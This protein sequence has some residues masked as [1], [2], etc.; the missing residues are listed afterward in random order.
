MVRMK[1]RTIPAASNLLRFTVP[2]TWILSKLP[3]ANLF[4]IGCAT[5]AG[6]LVSVIMLALYIKSGRW[7]KQQD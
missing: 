6:S 2:L 7:K 5:P 1:T 3:N 4:I